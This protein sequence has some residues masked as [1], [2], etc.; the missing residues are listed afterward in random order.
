MIFIKPLVDSDINIQ[1]YR[2][3]IENIIED[4]YNEMNNH[5]ITGKKNASEVT[6]KNAFICPPIDSGKS[7]YE[8]EISETN[9]ED[10]INSNPESIKF[11]RKLSGSAEF[12]QGKE[13]YCLWI[14]NSNLE[15]AL[16]IDNIKDRIEKVRKN[17]RVK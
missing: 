11:I 7:Y 16:K 3:A 12:I 15:E 5:F 4:H 10:L 9:F 14:N 1:K 2:E 17:R 6:V 13:R 8:E